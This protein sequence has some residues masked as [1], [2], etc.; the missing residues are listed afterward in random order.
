AVLAERRGRDQVER[1]RP[2]A[3]VDVGQRPDGAD[4][5]RVAGKI[6]LERLGFADAH[7]LQRT[8]LEHLD[9]RVAGYLLRE[10][11]APRAQH[12]PLTVEQDLR[13]QVYRLGVL[14]LGQPEARLRIAVRQSLVLRRALDRKSTRL[15]S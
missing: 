11:C 4:L 1:A 12:A 8:A 10:S 5:D 13:R 9:H 15:S 3:V 14:A 7:L 2:E 6:G